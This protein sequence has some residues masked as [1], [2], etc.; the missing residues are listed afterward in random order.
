MLVW[1]SV[2]RV[3]G[4]FSDSGVVKAKAEGTAEPL[5]ISIRTEGSAACCSQCMLHV[6]LSPKLAVPLRG[7]PMIRIIVF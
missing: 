5:M 6:R 1:G 4:F 3:A 7:I 2:H